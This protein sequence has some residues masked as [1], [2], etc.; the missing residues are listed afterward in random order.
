MR[1]ALNIEVKKFSVNTISRRDTPSDL[2]QVGIV[3][4]LTERVIIG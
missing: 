4:I 1:R 2:K 3:R